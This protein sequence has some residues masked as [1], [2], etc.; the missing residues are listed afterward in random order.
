MRFVR[1]FSDVGINDIEYVGGKNA[2]LGEMYRHLSDEGIKVPNGF[3]TTS[4]A[5]HYYMVHNDLVEKIRQALEKLDTNDV[6]A[7]AQTGRQIR[8]WILHAEMPKDLAEEIVEAM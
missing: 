4:Q 1:F 5:Y 6:K 7:L 3:A 2:S 8:S